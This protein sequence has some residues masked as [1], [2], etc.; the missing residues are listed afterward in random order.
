MKTA[1]DFREAFPPMDEGFRRAVLHALD[2]TGKERMIVKKKL[3]VSVVIAAVI[4]LLTAVAVA[5]GKTLGV[6]DFIGHHGTP[7]PQAEQQLQTGMK[8]LSSGA[9]QLQSGSSQVVTGIDK[10]N[11]GAEELS[12]GMNEFKD[13]GILPLTKAMNELLDTTDDIQS[14]LKALASDQ[15]SYKN[16]SG[17]SDGMTGSVKFVIETASLEK[18]D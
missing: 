4:V 5:A 8:Q 12:S 10:L 15:V 2:E 3:R 7:L 18:E 14:R 11:D 17:I 1:R 16:Y 9:E 13:D 6:F